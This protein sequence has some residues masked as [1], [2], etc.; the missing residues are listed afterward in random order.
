MCLGIDWIAEAASKESHNVKSLMAKGLSKHER[1]FP[2][3]YVSCSTSLSCRLG[4]INVIL[5]VNTTVCNR[6]KPFYSSF[7]E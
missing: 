1:N 4:M 6:E 3:D 7:V 2:T 5:I